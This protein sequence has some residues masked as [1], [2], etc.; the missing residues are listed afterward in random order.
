MVQHWRPKDF[1]TE[2]EV[3][4][5]PRGAVKLVGMRHARFGLDQLSPPEIPVIRLQTGLSYLVRKVNAPSGQSYVEGR[6]KDD[7]RETEGG[8]AAAWRRLLTRTHQ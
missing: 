7:E 3:L 4:I 6:S 8:N 2:A 5:W 1:K